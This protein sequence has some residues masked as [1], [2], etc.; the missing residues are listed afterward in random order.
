M[1]I[2]QTGTSTIGAV[3]GFS[4]PPSGST[5]T[6]T[7]SASARSFITIAPDRENVP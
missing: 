7:W 1:R 5:V 6:A 3:V 4:D 2:G